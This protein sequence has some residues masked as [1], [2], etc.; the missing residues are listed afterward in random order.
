MRGLGQRRSFARE[1]GVWLALWTPVLLTGCLL[2][3]PPDRRPVPPPV[4]AAPW[5]VGLS[6]R[7]GHPLSGRG[8]VLLEAPG[9]PVRVRVYE[10]AASKLTLAP[11][12][13]F[14]RLA[15]G[16]GDAWPSALGLLGQAGALLAKDQ[17][18]KVEP[19]GGWSTPRFGSCLLKGA[20]L[21]VDLGVASR[22]QLGRFRVS[23]FRRR[24]S[25]FGRVLVL[26]E[27]IITAA[28]A[29]RELVSLSEMDLI[30]RRLYLRLP[31]L[32][33]GLA[34][35]LVVIEAESAPVSGSEAALRHALR[36]DAAVEAL[37]V[38]EGADAER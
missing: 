7:S 38:R 12:G 33:A 8:E 32:P 36:R 6:H 25:S 5:R 24:G 27:L 21:T 19:E 23:L 17:T 29:R 37:A 13:A 34:G 31:D 15:L 2:C 9:L 26:I 30:G 14:V 10:R 35:P 28:P 22:E 20:C 1:L 4:R 11:L 18:V 16:E 3:A